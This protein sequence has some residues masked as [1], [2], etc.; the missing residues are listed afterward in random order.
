MINHTTK[1]DKQ[2][3]NIIVTSDDSYFI[4][5]ISN[6]SI[7][8]SHSFA[9]RSRPSELQDVTIHNL[10]VRG[11]RGNIVQV[12]PS[13]EYDFVPNVLFASANSYIHV[14]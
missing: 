9:I 14:Q 11:M 6:S 7:P 3:H 8:R 1:I 10:N 2:I 5:V 4:R 12:Y 13:V